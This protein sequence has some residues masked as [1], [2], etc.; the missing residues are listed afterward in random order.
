MNFRQLVEP[1]ITTNTDLETII[2]Y[3]NLGCKQC[4]TSTCC[5]S[6]TPVL[7]EGEAERI[8][9]YLSIPFDDLVSKGLLP[10]EVYFKNR[11]KPKKYNFYCI[12][13]VG[14]WIKKEKQIEEIRS[15]I[16]VSANSFLRLWKALERFTEAVTDVKILCGIQEVK[17][18]ECKTIY[19]GDGGKS[20]SWFTLN[21]LVDP[22]DPRTVELYEKEIKSG[23]LARLKTT[24]RS[25]L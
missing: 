20:A 4:K 21:Y 1:N 12:F 2:A 14:S 13:G 6:S 9:D 15:R 5:E 25:S 18:L 19:C 24:H 7:L 3:S 23:H 16:Y 11:F 22:D 10:T 17:P 8:A